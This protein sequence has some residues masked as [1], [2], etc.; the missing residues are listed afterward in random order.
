MGHAQMW[1]QDNVTRYPYLLINSL[2]DADGNPQPAGP[3][4]Y[5]RAPQV[6]PVMAALIQIATQA[7]SDLLGNQQAGEELQPNISGKAIELIQTRLDMQAFIY[8]SNFS[9]FMKR[10]GEVWLSMAKDILVEDD[11]QMK[12]VEPDGTLNTVTIRQPVV[13]PETGEQGMANDLDDAKFDV[14]SDVGPS[15]QSKRAAA[16]KAL[17]GMAQITT[18]P[19]MQQVIT[20][21]AIMN[22]EG[23]GLQDLRDFCRARLVKMGVIKPT[24]EEIQEL[25]A[26]AQNQVP[27]P[28][29]EYLAA[30]ARQADSDAALGHAKTIDTL[31][32]AKLK[33]AQTDKTLADAMAVMRQEHIENVQVLLSL[34]DA[35]NNQTVALQQAQPVDETEPA[36]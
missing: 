14:R 6:P 12:T 1:A 36:Q 27:D 30:A 19:E 20:S 21:A 25:T 10:C 31:A 22:M 32:S 23:E 9:K 17:T 29:A 8:M 18:D 3:I 24:N 11:R 15:S 35:Q 34:M 4:G 16:V 28:Q 13:D 5:T 2:R 33:D 7:L 26:Q